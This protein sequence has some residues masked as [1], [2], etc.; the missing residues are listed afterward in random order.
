MPALQL[1]NRRTIFAGDDLQPTAILT[2]FA[3]LAQF[4]LLVL[5]VFIHVTYECNY[6]LQPHENNDNGNEGDENDN[7]K[8]NNFVHYLF[9]NGE[10]FYDDEECNAKA[11]YFPL[12]LYIFLLLTTIHIIL[13]LFFE[14]IIYK[15]SSIGS[16]TQSELRNPLLG[17]MV[18]RKWIWLSIVGNIVVL[19]IGFAALGTSSFYFTCRDVVYEEREK[20][21]DN[22]ENGNQNYLDPNGDLL[23]LLFGKHTW[24]FLLI[25]LQSS[26]LVQLLVST[27]ALT[28]LLRKEKVGDFEMRT[29]L[30][31]TVGSGDSDGNGHGYERHNDHHHLHHE[32]A[33]EMWSQ[34]CQSF[35]KCAASS[36]CY[37]FGG[38]D[39]VD[40]VTGDYG[41]VSRAL[42]DYFEDGGVLDVATSDIAAGFMMLQRRQRQR[43]LAAR[44]RINDDLLH[45]KSQNTATE[46]DIPSS[47]S[48]NLHVQN[49]SGS[50]SSLPARKDSSNNGS[51]STLSWD[52]HNFG[53]ESHPRISS[54]VDPNIDPAT[55]TL[56][57]GEIPQYQNA[58]LHDSHHKMDED[59]LASILQP[60]PYTGT[61]L[62]PTGQLANT[63]DP[64][65]FLSTPTA[66]WTLKKSTEEGNYKAQKRKVFNRNDPI[67][68]N[69]IAEGARFAR[70]AL[71]IYTWVLYVYMKP[72][73]GPPNLIYNRLAEFCNQCKSK[74][75]SQN[76]HGNPDGYV[77]TDADGDDGVD[78][79]DSFFCNV[80]HGNTTG[81][82]CF[83][84]H[85]NSLLAHSGLDESDLIYANFNNKYNQMP[86]CIVIDHKWQSVVLAIRGTLSLEDCLVD[87]LVDPDP[88]DE[89][90]REYGFDGD[91]QY[92]HSGV[93]SCVK[94][95][96]NDLKR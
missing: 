83:H 23:S 46:L 48:R 79:N 88:L 3:H 28:S 17:N 58:S 53:Q 81:D 94:Y 4:L 31:S 66:A 18:E 27:F 9:G 56:Q 10:I 50:L 54:V 61:L 67:D 25:L 1:F 85:R 77:N 57:I 84:A 42:A 71:S 34:R 93:L 49:S 55:L 91:D 11:H 45:G 80:A 73:R 29:M 86:Y 95:I 70:H 68:T 63:N 14:S 75:S 47:S 90:G 37:L 16:P 38:R 52:A 19:S 87:V 62:L 96:L 65:D 33:E 76:S 74:H 92:C 35:C 44:K 41:Q 5:P 32:L 21:N 60:M 36:T 20:G 22:N 78:S 43:I 40:G 8:F 39:L 30:L 69:V 7:G 59:L 82:N 51:S 24:W 2:S 89:L 13:S 64:A 6:M 15:L 12:L 72:L 26:Q